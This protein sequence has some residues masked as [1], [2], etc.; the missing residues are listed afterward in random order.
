M[1]LDA[2]TVATLTLGDKRDVIHFD[3]VLT[4]FGIRLRRGAGDRILRSWVVQ[5]KR[6]G[7][8]RR[9]LIGSAEKLTAEQARTA[10]KKV[11]AKIT[12]GEDPQGDKTKRRDDDKSTFRSVV[13]EYLNQKSTGKKPLRPNTL[14]ETRRYLT[15]PYFKP[16]HAKP[17]DTI[18]RR[19][20]ALRVTA[21]NNNSGGAAASRARA[22][23]SALFIK[24]PEQSRGARGS[25]VVASI[26]ASKRGGGVSGGRG[27]PGWP[28]RDV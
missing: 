2:D 16:L 4:G 21:I 19:D 26:W 25:G 7:A 11:L 20:V 27:P 23:L 3:D 10:A 28:I 12:L 6:G 15:G 9:Y 1:K 14:R 17:I 22:V 8:T 5:Y 24:N 13:T 18:T